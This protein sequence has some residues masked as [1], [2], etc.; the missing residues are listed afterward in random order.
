MSTVQNKVVH[1][2]V[3]N[4]SEYEE[5]GQYFNQII[6]VDTQAYAYYTASE[7]NT[8][9]GLYY[10]IGDGAHTYVEIR[11]G[12]GSVPFSK[13]YYTTLIVDADLDITST[14]PIENKRVAQEIN[15][16]N[17]KVTTL[18]QEISTLKATLEQVLSKISPTE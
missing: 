11:D 7:D 17:T 10:V 14:N 1:R 8:K 15:S 18:E 5:N 9:E 4:I 6:P 16:L 2:F 3:K 13:E 12:K